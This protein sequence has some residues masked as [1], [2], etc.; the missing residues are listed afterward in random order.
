MES[1]RKFL[2]SSKKY[3]E[4]SE[5]RDKAFKVID[6][7]NYYSMEEISRIILHDWYKLFESLYMHV[8]YRKIKDYFGQLKECHINRDQFFAK[9]KSSCDELNGKIYDLKEKVEKQRK[10]FSD[11]Y[12]IFFSTGLTN[13]ADLSEKMLYSM[14]TQ[15]EA[16][17]A[18]MEFLKT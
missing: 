18:I 16:K 6:Y 2:E 8:D 17:E 7:P 10:E 12:D 11:S 3:D 4:V 15:P 9:V 1:Y 13:A 14:F 5:L